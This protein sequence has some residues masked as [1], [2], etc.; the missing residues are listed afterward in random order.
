M[1]FY[2]RR[3]RRRRRRTAR[4][5]G[6]R[7]PRGAG[8]CRRSFICSRFLLAPESIKGRPSVSRCQ[9]CQADGVCRPLLPSFRF[10]ALESGKG[11]WNQWSVRW[12][13]PFCRPLRPSSFGCPSSGLPRRG[14]VGRVCCQPAA[15]LLHCY[16]ATIRSSGHA[17]KKQQK[18][19]GSHSHRPHEAGLVGVFGRLALGVRR[20]GSQPGSR[21]PSLARAPPEKAIRPPA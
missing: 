2:A 20:S 21:R 8:P 10:S 17:K 19:R 1:T 5:P 9:R 6:R 13:P 12:P 3:C 18:S 4:R 15:T 7:S 16:A 14:R 11:M